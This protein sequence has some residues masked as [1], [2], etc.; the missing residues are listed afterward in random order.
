MAVKTLGLAADWWSDL[1]L[2]ERFASPER[3]SGATQSRKKQ[4][5][6]DCVFKKAPLAA[7]YDE[8]NQQLSYCYHHQL[9]G[10]IFV[11]GYTCQMFVWSM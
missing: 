8:P 7:L 6:Q 2:S 4:R 5:S 11:L 9:N 10:Q 1:G 3:S